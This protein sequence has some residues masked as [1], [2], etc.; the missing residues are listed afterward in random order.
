[1]AKDSTIVKN[2]I[3]DF[4]HRL[5]TTQLPSVDIEFAKA[6]DDE[7]VRFCVDFCDARNFTCNVN[8]PRFRR[9]YACV[10]RHA[11]RVVSANPEVAK[12]REFLSIPREVLFADVWHAS[13]SAYVERLQNAYQTKKV[14]KTRQYVCP[15]CKNRECDFYEMQCRSA[16]ESM[17]LFITC[18][19]CDHQWRIG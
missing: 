16:D 7:V 11:I 14:A 15:K 19:T 1:M 3:R 6:I 17:T 5:I 10:L 13:T 2:S 4:A 12:T 8:N 18:L 9:L